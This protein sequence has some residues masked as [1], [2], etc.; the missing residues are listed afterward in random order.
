MVNNDIWSKYGND[1]LTLCK[2]CLE[3]RMGREL[4]KKDISQHKDALVNLHNPEM[5]D[6]KD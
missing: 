1:K 5:K 6:L 2:S 3:K 4:T